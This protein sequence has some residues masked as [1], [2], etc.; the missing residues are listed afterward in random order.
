VVKRKICTLP[1][2]KSWSSSLCLNHLLSYVSPKQHK[3]KW[4]NLIIHDDLQVKYLHWLPT[5]FLHYF[6]PKIP[7]K[8]CNSTPQPSLYFVNTAKVSVH[9]INSHIHPKTAASMSE[10]LTILQQS[11]QLIP[12]KSKFYTELQPPKH[13]NKNFF[14]LFL[15]KET[16]FI[17]TTWCRIQKMHNS[18][19]STIIL[20][21]VNPHYFFCSLLVVY[22]TCVINI[23]LC[24]QVFWI[25][26][27]SPF[28]ILAVPK[29]F[30]FNVLKY[31]LWILIFTHT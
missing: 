26:P 8:M 30:H 17:L 19:P 29:T 2:I 4:V 12:I 10:H 13:N 7:C 20:G 25:H 24:C 1:W 14:V 22:D 27:F 15:L 11:T 3:K 23:F 5:T 31:V 9:C 21:Q 6:G 28:W 18:L 16:F